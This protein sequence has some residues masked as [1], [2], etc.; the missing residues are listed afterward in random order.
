TISSHHIKTFLFTYME[1]NYLQMQEAQ[2]QADLF[3]HI[4]Q[5]LSLALKTKSMSN[6]FISDIDMLRLIPEEKCMFLAEKLDEFHAKPVETIKQMKTNFQLLVRWSRVKTPLVDDYSKTQIYI[7]H[8]RSL[9]FLAVKER[10]HIRLQ[11]FQHIV[12]LSNKYFHTSSNDTI[13]NVEELLFTWLNVTVTPKLRKS[14]PTCFEQEGHYPIQRYDNRKLFWLTYNIWEPI[15]LMFNMSDMYFDEEYEQDSDD[16]N[17]TNTSDIV[18][19][20]FLKLNGVATNKRDYNYIPIE[21]YH[22]QNIFEVFLTM[23]CVPLL[24]LP[25]CTD[26]QYLIDRFRGIGIKNDLLA[27]AFYDAALEKSIVV[28][29]LK[30]NLYALEKN[31][32]ICVTINIEQK[33]FAE[34]RHNQCSEQLKNLFCRALELSETRTLEINVNMC[35]TYYF[36]FGYYDQAIDKIKTIIQ[37]YTM[38][39]E[40]NGQYT[41]LS[42]IEFSEASEKCPILW[43]LSKKLDKSEFVV[44]SIVLAFYTLFQSYRMIDQWDNGQDY[45]EQFQ[46]VCAQLESTFQEDYDRAIVKLLLAASFMCLALMN[47]ATY[48]LLEFPEIA[49]E[50]TNELLSLCGIRCLVCF[51]DDNSSSDLDLTLDLP[52]ALSECGDDNQLIHITSKSVKQLPSMLVIRHGYDCYK[53]RPWLVNS[54]TIL[55]ELQKWMSRLPSS[56]FI[57]D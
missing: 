13:S 22:L 1:G 28:F 53:M 16:E 4:V 19:I 51:S 33:S 12:N 11:R 2:E 49:H 35:Y 3:L 9:L 32:P 6:Y 17:D 41:T 43:Y 48:I 37:V 29:K 50:L 40:E 23:L 14:L 46:R 7:W 24:D 55:D 44:P 34:D 25:T 36:L 5:C 54:I 26:I 42:T 52:Y 47:E 57:L 8:L 21:K 31:D 38:N 27:N 30:Q 39:E 56:D 15:V 18:V 45:I 20:P 10:D